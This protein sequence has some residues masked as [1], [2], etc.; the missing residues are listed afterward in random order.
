MDTSNITN[1]QQEA[2]T[3]LKKTSSVYKFNLS[4]NK[5]DF[6]S[7]CRARNLKDE[8]LREIRDNF[9]TATQIAGLSDKRAEPISRK[10]SILHP[11]S[12]KLLE[13]I[14]SLA[15]CLSSHKKVKRVMYK[16]GKRSANYL[17]IKWNHIT[18]DLSLTLPPIPSSAQS[19]CAILTS[20]INKIDQT[21]STP[22]APTPSI[23]SFNCSSTNSTSTAHQQLSQEVSELR[24]SLTCLQREFNRLSAS[25]KH[26]SIQHCHLYVSI[27]GSLGCITTLQNTLGCPIIQLTPLSTTS[28]KVKIDRSHIWQALS[29]DSTSVR[30]RLWKNNT[31][32]FSRSATGPEIRVNSSHPA[33]SLNIMSWNC[34]G[35]GTSEPYLRFLS[36]SADI[37]LIQ[38]HWL[39]PYELH[40]FSSILSNFSGM[41]KADDRLTDTSELQRGCGGVGIMWRKSLNVSV[42][43]S[44]TKSDR[45]CCIEVPLSCRSPD[46]LIIINIYCPSSDSSID[47]YT[48]CLHD[49]EKTVCTH[50]GTNCAIIIAGDLNAH[51]GTLAGHRGSGVFNQR[52]LLLKELI[53]RNSLFVSSHSQWSTGPSYTFHSGDHFTTVDYIIT[54]RI[55]A[56]FLGQSKCMDEHSLNISDHLPLNI[57]LEVNPLYRS[58]TKVEPKVDW[59]KAADSE[60]SLLL[61]YENAVKEIVSPF[62]ET[63]NTCIS[64]LENEISLVCVSIHRAAKDLL[65]K[66]IIKKRRKNFFKDDHLNLLCKQSKSAWRSWKLAHKPLVGPLFESMKSAKKQVHKKINSLQARKERLYYNH[67]DKKCKERHNNRFKISQT[68]STHG[69]RLAVDDNLVSDKD[70]VM[71]AWATHFKNLSTSKLTESPSLCDLEPIISRYRATSFENEDFIFN[72]NITLEEVEGAIKVLKEGKAC[73]PDNILPE[74]IIYGGGCLILWLKKIFNEVIS[75]EDIPSSFKEATIVPIY[76]GK[77]SDPLQTQNYR[78]IS[79]SSVVGKLLERIMLGRI[80]PILEEKGI[81]HLTQTAYQ[82]GVSCGDAT[83]AVQEIIKNYIDAGSSAFQCFYDLEKAFDSVEYNVLLNHLY[84]AGINGKGWRVI[85]AFYKDPSARVRIN[86][87]LSGSFILGRGVKQGSVLSPILFLLVIDSLLTDLESSGLGATMFGHYLGSLGHADDIRSISPNLEIIEQQAS[88]VTKFTKTNGLN[89]NISK[90]ELQEHSITKHPPCSIQV[91][92]TIITSTDSATC[93]GVKWSHDLSPKKSI[94]HNIAKA[95]RAFFALSTK[96]IHGKLNP[97]TSKEMFETCVLPVCL[98]GAE[99]WILTQ[100]LIKLLEDFQAE[101]GKRIL[102]IPKHHSNL[103]PLVALH[104]PSMRLRILQQKLSFLWRLLHPKKTTINVKVMLSLRE[105]GVEPILVQQCK[106]LE[107]VYGSNSTDTMLQNNTDYDSISLQYIKKTLQKADINLT[108]DRISSR[109]SL[110]L[111]SHDINWMKLWDVAREYGIQG[112][113]SITSA[114]KTITIPVFS[115]EYQCQIC[116]FVFTKGTPPAA[117]LSETHLGCS[118]QHLL[119]LL[120]DPCEETF[121]TT[122]SLKFLLRKVKPV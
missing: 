115:D 36:D 42:T 84:R 98:Y 5:I 106:F 81:P 40:K 58:E 110:T 20:T 27:H 52:G 99:N 9:F 82:K 14:W 83:E 68:G 91:G 15:D 104:W 24:K 39:W 69:M 48:Q 107:Q 73:G 105:N 11:L 86:G 64:E 31:H 74:H 28:F 111:L 75:F 79:L 51:L 89:L 78:G 53:D 65:P 97:L 113:R 108:W 29:K 87:D 70:E 112:A 114:L 17:D 95:R 49:L 85:G 62:L 76:K 72:Y 122:A 59:K 55:A 88:I 4:L 35:L 3:F 7:N 32:N 38:E 16:S 33:N 18:Q 67:Q 2:L 56:E 102:N 109:S 100:N 13:D 10:G 25:Q 93:L 80:L 44:P 77:G 23:S 54:N 66:L 63:T 57:T 8:L 94:E 118:L 117:H 47:Y 119:N 121:S 92:E 116:D 60:K 37:I 50:N 103:I 43:T 41:G 12:E 61:V 34:R 6:I 19:D 45:I 26:S 30:V 22:V 21:I 101:I 96:G 71:N 90:L 1:G 46:K 120:K